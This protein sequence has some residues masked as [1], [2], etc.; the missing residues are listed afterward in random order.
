MILPKPSIYDLL[1]IFVPKGYV[2]EDLDLGLDG[3]SGVG[4]SIILENSYHDEL[5]FNN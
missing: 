1:Y 3:N 5:L 2:M 4:L